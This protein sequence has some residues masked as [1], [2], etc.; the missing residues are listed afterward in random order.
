MEKNN[1]QSILLQKKPWIDNEHLIWIVSTISLARNI[2]KYHFPGKL[3][4][5]KQK[6]IIS[7]IKKQLPQIKRLKKAEFIGADKTS[8]LEKEFLIEHYLTPH[9]FHQS[10]AGEGF[11]ID[12]SGRFLG[13]VNV[14]D[15]LNLTLLETDTE[16]EKSWNQLVEIE[17]KIGEALS[18]SFSQKFGFLT[19]DPVNCGTGLRVSVFLQLSG[20]IHTGQIEQTLEKHA[21][22]NIAITGIHGNPNEIIGDILV[23]QNNY[24]LGITEENIISNIR[25]CCTKLQVEEKSVRN[26]IIKSDNTEIKD[27][28]SR[29]YA[30]LLHSYNIEAI[31]SLN[32]ISLLK[33]G[34]QFGWIKGM[35][36]KK[37]NQLF[38]NCRRAH[39]LS[40]FGEEIPQDQLPHKR[41]EYIHKSLKGV[42]LV[43]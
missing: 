14:R 41:A 35:S 23:I 30:V 42:E 21:D 22:E 39:L 38:F 40:E 16:L 27:R 10:H 6:Q 12:S 26:E 18:Y 32:A 13:S 25:S 36:I 3:D 37:A 33:L 19:A 20:L 4:T 9:S 7:F 11:I 28:I 15:H 24:S 2:S 34:I 5:T 1:K 8:P 31:E 29:A 43:I 17:S